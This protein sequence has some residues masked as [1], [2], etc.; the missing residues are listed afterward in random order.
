MGWVKTNV[1]SMIFARESREARLIY[2]TLEPGEIWPFLLSSNIKNIH[3]L[4]K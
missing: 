4:G 1:V 3:E 2:S